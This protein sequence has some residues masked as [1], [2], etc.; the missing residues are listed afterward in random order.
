MHY[1]VLLG[2]PGSGKGTQAGALAE[3]L[4]AIHLSTGDLFRENIA[5]QTPLGRQVK[6]FLDRGAYVPD[7]VT[8]AMVFDRLSRPDAANGAIFDGFPRTI[9]QA[10]ALDTGLTERSAAIERAI[11]L[12]VADD[13]L[14][15]RLGGRWLCR[16]C[17]TP[18]HLTSSPPRTS[19]V[20]DHDGGALYQRDDDKPD[21]VAHRLQVYR[22]QTLPLIGYYRAQ[23]KLAEVN[24]AGEIDSIRQALH[25]AALGTTR[26]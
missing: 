9:A 18:Y 15:R 19:G 24:G 10:Q 12:D 25:A 23:G 21:V 17:S 2:P 8:V 1:V 4:G 5:Q 3:A 6:E 7:D 20:C 11:V 16:T 14:I 13:E 22:D 26:L